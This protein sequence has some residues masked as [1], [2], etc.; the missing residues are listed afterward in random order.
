[1]NI[2]ILFIILLSIVVSSAIAQDKKKEESKPTY[3]K[4][5]KID[6]VDA[7]HFLTALNKWK[8]L[9]MYNPK[10]SAEQKVQT[11]QELDAYIQALGNR[12]KIDSLIV[13]MDTVKT[14]KKK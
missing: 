7:Q 2:K 1:M 14:K 11:F 9:E 10:S 12:L 6:V 13:T 4:F 5:V 3:I 8:E